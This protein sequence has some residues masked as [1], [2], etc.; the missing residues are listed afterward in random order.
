MAL[1]NRLVVYN[2]QGEPVDYDILASDVKFLPDGK[3]LP[4]KLAELED[5]IG[6][7]GYAPPEGGIP[8]TDLAESVQDSLDK[9]DSALQEEDVAEVAKT[10]DYN[11][12]EHKPTIPDTSGLATKTELNAKQDTL[13]AGNGIVV[14]QDGKTV[15]VDAEV[16]QPVTADGTF[17]VR[18]GGNTYT[19]NLNHSH[20]QY[21]TAQLLKA[22]SNVS[23][24]VNQQTGEVTINAAG[25][26]GGSGISGITMN[27]NAVPVGSNGVVDLG[28]V[29]TS[30]AGYVL[31]SALA[32][33][34]TSGSYN[35]LSNKPDLSGLANIGKIVNAKDNT[36]KQ[37]WI[38]TQAEYNSLT[39]FDNNVLYLIKA[40]KN[41]A[42]ITLSAGTPSQNSVQLTA[43]ISPA[44]ADDVTLAWSISEDGTNY[45]NDTTHFSIN[46]SGLLTIKEGADNASVT[47]KC[48][49]VNEAS[50]TASATLQLTGLSYQDYIQFEDI[51]KN[52]GSLMQENH[53]NRHGAQ[54]HCKE[55]QRVQ[56]VYRNA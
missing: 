39:T 24:S 3:D 17:A 51:L 6:Q 15:S 52:M 34:A 23:I 31:S 10:G 53:M 27:G 41:I 42:G 16:V 50:G 35:D 2:E 47:V 5:E 8:K 20:P 18:I 14:A 26:S 12:L 46:S 55:I 19:I 40:T 38:G 30:L 54:Q 7:G 48:Q 44:G 21:L 49:D 37:L 1:D 43:T 13:V 22:G 33:V 4:T 56:V 45:S 36:T 25:G 29:I 28:T 9:A 11:D 32:A